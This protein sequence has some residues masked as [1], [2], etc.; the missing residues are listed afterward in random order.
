MR[1][2]SRGHS[3]EEVS[4]MEMERRT[5][6]LKLRSFFLEIVKANVKGHETIGRTDE[7]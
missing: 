6:S 5:E 1:E 2:V 3:S 7:P 4:V